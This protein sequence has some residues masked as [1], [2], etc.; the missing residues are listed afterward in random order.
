MG[1]SFV[2]DINYA[3]RVCDFNDLN[4]DFR[5]LPSSS[6]FAAFTGAWGI[7]DGLVGLVGAFVTALPWIAVIVFD[8][9]AAIFYIAAGIVSFWQ[10]QEDLGACTDFLSLE[11][12]RPAIELWHLRRSLYQVDDHDRLQLPRTHYHG[13]HHSDRVLCPKTCLNE[14]T[15]SMNSRCDT[16][17]HRRSVQ[18]RSICWRSGIGIGKG[19]CIQGTGTEWACHLWWLR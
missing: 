6:Y 1:V 17:S 7:L 5:R 4:C 14:Q 16:R 13:R 12:R 3:R 2:R 10:R 15:I 11:P 8:A 9:L 19:R 18:D